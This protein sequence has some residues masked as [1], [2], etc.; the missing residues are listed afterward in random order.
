MNKILKTLTDVKTELILDE[1]GTIHN[2]V[3]VYKYVDQ[4]Y[5]YERGDDFHES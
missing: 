5:L 2:C 1:N 3:R 4:K